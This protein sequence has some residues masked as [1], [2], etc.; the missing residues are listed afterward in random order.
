MFYA[1]LKTKLPECRFALRTKFASQSHPTD[2]ALYGSVLGT[3][4][5]IASK[6]LNY[7][8]PVEYTSFVRSSS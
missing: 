2:T 8:G 1:D 5:T 6:S 4:A 7:F 3:I